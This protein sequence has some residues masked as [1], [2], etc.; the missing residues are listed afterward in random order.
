MLSPLLRTSGNEVS[1]L[2][3]RKGRSTHIG[4]D[5]A[6]EAAA[7]TVV[8]AS[9]AE[10]T[11]AA[12]VGAVVPTLVAPV[13]TAIVLV[14]SVPGTLLDGEVH[15][16]VQHTMLGDGHDDGLVVGGSVDG[17]HAVDAFRQPIR[18]VGSKNTVLRCLV[19]TLRRV[20]ELICERK[21]L[22][23]P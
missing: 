12:V 21:R 16:V 2:V 17:A 3:A 1:I 10:A 14:A 6:T 9:A 8:E 13:V 18:H 15:N 23:I 5:E 20:S 7:E 19:Q 11:K 22:H 4:F